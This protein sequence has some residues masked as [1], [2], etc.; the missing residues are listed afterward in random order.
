MSIMVNT[1]PPAGSTSPTLA[2]RYWMRPSRGATSVL[3]AMLI[4][5]S[6]TSLVAALERVLGLGD[7]R[8]GGVQRGVG[9]I[10]LLLALVEQFAGRVAAVPQVFGALELLVRQ[11]RPA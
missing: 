2:M 5:S 8:S 1:L 6:S 9:G 3:S 7:P 11:A 4:L 10:E